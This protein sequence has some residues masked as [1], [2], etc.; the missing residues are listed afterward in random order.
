MEAENLWSRKV[1]R[2]HL[3]QSQ[4][5]GI[6][7]VSSLTWLLE[8]VAHKLI[9]SS[10]NQSDCIKGKEELPTNLAWFYSWNWWPTSRGAGNQSESCVA[11]LWFV[12][13]RQARW[14]IMVACARTWLGNTIPHA[15]IEKIVLPKGLPKSFSL[16]R[17][18]YQCVPG[19]VEVRAAP[20]CGMH[21]SKVFVEFLCLNRRVL[22][23]LFFCPGTLHNFK[24]DPEKLLVSIIATNLLTVIVLG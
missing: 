3:L 22:H 6:E 1:N 13:I 17:K 11:R 2:S 19:R 12:G 18:L 14:V 15:T 24:H 10:E 23:C 4:S 20:D 21:G 9:T 5:C 7:E 16:V 8:L